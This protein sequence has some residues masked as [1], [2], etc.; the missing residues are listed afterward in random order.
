M[1]MMQAGLVLLILCTMA[2]LMIS[3]I[4][5]SRHALSFLPI[6]GGRS[7]ARNLHMVSAYWGVL[8][9]VHL[10][11]HWSIAPSIWTMK[12]EAKRNSLGRK[13]HHERKNV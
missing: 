10:G 9:S 4:I 11:F 3:G 2:G 8:M 6:K 5:H 13:E 12:T 1:R 7:F